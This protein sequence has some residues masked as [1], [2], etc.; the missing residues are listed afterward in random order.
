MSLRPLAE[1]IGSSPRVLL[2]LFGSKD[3]LVGALLARARQDE[4]AVLEEVSAGGGTLPDAV[5]RIWDWLA[6]PARRKLLTL[7]AEAYAQSL[8]DPNGAWAGFARHTVTDWLDLL[9]AAQSNTARAT[10]SAEATR[11]ALLALL[12]G[13]LPDLLATGDQER[14]TAAVTMATAQLEAG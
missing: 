8:I 14:V 13:A 11:T 10:A 2:F 1:A 4:R 7:W 5:L 9:A 6:D 12:R 3:G